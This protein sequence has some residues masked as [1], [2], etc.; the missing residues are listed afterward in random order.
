MFGEHF[1]NSLLF[2]GNKG[3]RWSVLSSVEKGG[4]A[5]NGR[6]R[7]GGFSTNFYYHPF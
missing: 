7:M 6:G 3:V 4:G 2:T 5:E 1:T